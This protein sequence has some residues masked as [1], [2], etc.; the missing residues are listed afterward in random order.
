MVVRRKLF[1]VEE[2]R[3]FLD[4]P[5][6]ADRRFELIDGE[7]VEMSPK[8][9]H[10]LVASVIH[11]EIYLYLKQNPIGKAMFEVDHYLPQDKY[12]TR[13]P[14][15]SFIGNDRLQALQG[16]RAVPLMPDL[17]VEV[18]SPSN[19]YT[20][21]EGLREKAQY[22][23][24]QGSRLVWLV[25]PEKQQIEVYVPDGETRILT[26]EDT[27]EGGEVLPGFVLPVREIFPE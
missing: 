9:D 2:F 1:T 10:G 27:L 26:I 18:K 11:G 7:I 12:N 17:A 8:L 21:H 16:D 4:L 15:V 25:D 5:E 3:H 22:Y 24:D 14:D 6:N 19:Y 20:G 23:L 13:R